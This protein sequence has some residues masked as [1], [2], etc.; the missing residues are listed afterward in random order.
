MTCPKELRCFVLNYQYHDWYTL[1]VPLR[2]GAFPTHLWGTRS[3]PTFSQNTGGPVVMVW[4]FLVVAC[5]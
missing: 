5:A 2:F 4:G 3:L 1:I